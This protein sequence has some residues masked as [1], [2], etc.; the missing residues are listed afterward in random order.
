M[1]KD[2]RK[3][4]RHQPGE[5]VEQELR[6]Y[7]PDGFRVPGR[8]G[9]LTLTESRPNPHRD[10]YFDGVHK[11][12]LVLRCDG[13]SLRVRTKATGELLATFKAKRPDQG[14]RSQR[15]ETESQVLCPACERP[16]TRD[17]AD[18]CHICAAHDN[19][20]AL[21]AHGECAALSKARE[22]A[23]KVPLMFM[24]AI[25]NDRVDHHYHGPGGAHV[26]LSED[27]I[28]YPDG[29]TERRVEVEHVTGDPQLLDRID[30]ELRGLHPSL[31]A[32]KRG[33][34]SEGRRRMAALLAAA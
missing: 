3:S 19:Y 33:K 1:A 10:R 8:L 17:G 30:G 23:D 32:C 14:A 27:F 15:A 20:V 11:G 4:H 21:V 25:A 28:T 13:Y 7:R 6:Y 22:S 5:H 16:A 24:F 29:S 2:K 12:R 34:L 31:R 26:V 18:G 9:G